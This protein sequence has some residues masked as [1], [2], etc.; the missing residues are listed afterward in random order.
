M[1]P[2][3]N[4][5]KVMKNTKKNMIDFMLFSPF[6]SEDIN[7]LKICEKNVILLSAFSMVYHFIIVI[8]DKIV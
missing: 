5:Q 2:S 6:I 7:K 1:L 3:P 4:S 8:L